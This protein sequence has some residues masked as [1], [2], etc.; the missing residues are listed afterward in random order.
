MIPKIILVKSLSLSNVEIKSDYIYFC[1]NLHFTLSSYISENVEIINILLN[2]GEDLNAYV[3]IKAYCIIEANKINLLMIS[4][5][6]ENS[7]LF[8]LLINYKSDALQ[9]DKNNKNS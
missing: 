5:M 4:I 3:Q 6:T 2:S 7:K 8:N 9:E 1:Q